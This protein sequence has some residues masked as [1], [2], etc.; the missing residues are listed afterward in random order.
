[1]RRRGGRGKTPSVRVLGVDPGSKR[2]GLALSDE[3][4]TLAS[5]L[6]TV[7]V[8]GRDAA[9]ARVV[10]LARAHAVTALVV[11]LPLRLDGT[12]GPEA[13]RARALGD[14]LSADLEVPVVY[15]DERFTTAQ[16]E[17]ELS[18][19][20]KRGPARRAV[21]DQAAATLLLQS[22]LDAQSGPAEPGA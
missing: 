17:R 10:T 21:V 22:W 16:A 9:V 11:G 15:W 13:G 14:R 2:I 1:L 7:D 3:D 8:D 12:E 4:R 20:G 18:A 5:P 6:E 19:V